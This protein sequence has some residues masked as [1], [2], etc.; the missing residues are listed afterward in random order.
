MRIGGVSTVE[1]A[2]QIAE[3]GQYRLISEVREQL[4]LEGYADATAQFTSRTLTKDLRR[5]LDAVRQDS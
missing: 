4:R 2:Y 1:R 3:T 5:V